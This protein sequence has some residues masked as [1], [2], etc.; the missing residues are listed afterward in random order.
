MSSIQDMLGGLA[1]NS[2]TSVAMI[3]A[4]AVLK[5]QP[6][7]RRVYYAKWVKMGVDAGPQNAN[8]KNRRVG[9]Y[10]NL[11]LRNYLHVMDWIKHSL[12][13][14]EEE[15]IHHAGLDSAIFLRLLLLG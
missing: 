1:I 15:L 8:P 11:N 4:Y 12:S 7:N 13:M 3:C 9:R 14:S 2:A 10:I 6:I 5:D